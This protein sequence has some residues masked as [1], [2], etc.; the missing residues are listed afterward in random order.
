[1]GLI[2]WFYHIKIFNLNQKYNCCEVLSVSDTDRLNLTNFKISY[3]V[4]VVIVFV[5]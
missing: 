5:L 1:M 2:S 4:L 3:K